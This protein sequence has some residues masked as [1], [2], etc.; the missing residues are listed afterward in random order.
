MTELSTLE[1]QTIN[2]KYALIGVMFVGIIS[3]ILIGFAVSV[4]KARQ[5]QVVIK[6]TDETNQLISANLQQFETLFKNVFDTCKQEF[7]AT[8]STPNAYR[9]DSVDCKSAK[10]VLEQIN[11][12]STKDSSAIAYIRFPNGKIEI[13]EASGK[14]DP[15]QTPQDA[16]Q[17]SWQPEKRTALTEYF[18]QGKSIPMWDDYISYIPGKE[19]IVPVKSNNQI[20]G[21]IF[22][23][24]IE[25]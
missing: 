6:Y 16:Y 18:A 5:E 20:I 14:Y 23:G 11:F 2:L 21:Y 13:I 8:P 1:P 12:G 17:L 15:P 25:R 10:T 22:R 24:V 4:N 9:I 19:V 7:D 3:A